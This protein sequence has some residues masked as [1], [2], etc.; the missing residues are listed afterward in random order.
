MSERL[1]VLI[2][3]G[4]GYI[5][6]ILT[7]ALLDAGHRVTVLDNFMFRQVSLAHVCAH[8]QFDVARGDARDESVLRPLLKDADVIIPLAA[9]VGAPLCDMDKAAAE[10]VNRDAVLSLIKLSSAQQRIMMPVTNSGY[11]VGE[12]GKFCTE[13]SPL[14]PISL[15]GRTKV[16]AEKAVLDRGNA[17]SFRLATV[18]GMAPRMRIDLL[19]NDFVYRAVNDRAVVLFEPHFKRNYIHIRDVARAFL[20]GLDRFETMKDRPYNVGLSDANL[21]KWELCEQIRHHL[22]RFVFLE[23]PIGEDPDKRDYIVSNA[24]I[25]ATGYQPAYSLD[26]GVAELIKGYR[27]LRNAVHGNV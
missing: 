15:Y 6:S 7:P 27:M 10:G 16:E 18:F 24:R 23:A 4:A 3:G 12:A 13:E 9:L 11:G 20:H 19:V 21:S 26:D 22:P 8:P 1:N 5:G 14:R 2:T 25:E 17:I